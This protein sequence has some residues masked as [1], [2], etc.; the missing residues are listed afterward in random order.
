[1]K[2]NLKTLSA[3]LREM[4]KD[5][6]IKRKV[7]RHEKPVR[8]EYYLTDKGLALQPILDIMAAYSMKY[9]NRCKYTAGILLKFRLAK[10][11]VNNLAVLL[12]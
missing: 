7:Y 8:I 12:P 4:E 2:S 5:G 9:C 1:M 11:S 6:L 3:R 10:C